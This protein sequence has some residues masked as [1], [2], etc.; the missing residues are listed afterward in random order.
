MLSFSAN[1][2]AE[3]NRIRDLELE[4]A[5]EKCKLEAE[6]K[7]SNELKLQLEKQMAEIRVFKENEVISI[8]KWEEKIHNIEMVRQTEDIKQSQVTA[9]N[10]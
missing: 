10:E 1:K 5:Q 7:I 9:V 8:K 2:T 4:L 3:K 6:R